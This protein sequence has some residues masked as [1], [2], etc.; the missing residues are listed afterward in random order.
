MK[1]LTPEIAW[2]ETLPIYSCDLQPFTLVS[3]TID[4]GL[5]EPLVELSL[6]DEAS[7]DVEKL[8]E[9]TTAAEEEDEKRTRPVFGETWTRLATAGGDS[10]VR[11]WRVHLD[12]RPPGSVTVTTF[13]KPLPKGMLEGNA[14]STNKKTS[15]G[16]AAASTAMA[17]VAAGDDV[18]GGVKVSAP[19][20]EGLVFLATLKRHER[21]VNVVRWSPSGNQAFLFINLPFV[22]LITYRRFYWS[23]PS[24]TLAI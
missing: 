22:K 13:K 3:Q 24:Q 19:V 17:T 14:C 15:S 6:N 8:K 20:S 9:E 21:L 23:R 4:L 1:V 5:R 10:M 11:M 2:H 7:T 12:W 16:A 18:I